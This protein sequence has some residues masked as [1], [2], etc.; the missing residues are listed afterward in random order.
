MK[1]EQKSIY[2]YLS[3]DQTIKLTE[4]VRDVTLTFDFDEFVE[5]L[6][7][8]AGPVCLFECLCVFVCMSAFVLT[9]YRITWFYRSSQYDVQMLKY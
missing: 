4:K 6:M 1:Q 5:A 2:A 3:G 8:Q 9:L 7:T